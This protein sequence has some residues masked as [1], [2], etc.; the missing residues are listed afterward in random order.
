MAFG[1]D[2]AFLGTGQPSP[3]YQAFIAVLKDVAFYLDNVQVGA[4][5]GCR[6][7][8]GVVVGKGMLWRGVGCR[9][10]AQQGS[11]QGDLGCT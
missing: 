11:A 8:A 9:W 6:A 10:A 7:P 3:L 1:E 5:A 4:W 2:L